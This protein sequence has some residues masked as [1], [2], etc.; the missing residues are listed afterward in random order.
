MQQFDVPQV[1]GNAIVDEATK[2]LLKLASDIDSEEE[3]T[4]QECSGEEDDEGNRDDNV[5]D[6]IDE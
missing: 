5:K 3:T 6:W 2:E 1:K 4:A